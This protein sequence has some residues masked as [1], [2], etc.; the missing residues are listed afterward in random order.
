MIQDTRGEMKHM[1]ENLSEEIRQQDNRLREEMEELRRDYR[2]GERTE[3]GK[4]MLREEMEK[5]SE[6]VEGLERRWRKLEE[7][8]NE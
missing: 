2:A 6:R 5:L 3:G 4:R 8:R 1:M 7:G